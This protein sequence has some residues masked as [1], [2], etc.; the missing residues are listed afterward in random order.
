MISSNKQYQNTAN[1][2]ADHQ[3]KRQFLQRHLIERSLSQSNHN[4]Q[5]TLAA[6]ELLNETVDTYYV[7]NIQ[8]K[9]LL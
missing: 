9:F 1:N 7:N 2:S 6:K 8:K 5:H 4:E 3:N